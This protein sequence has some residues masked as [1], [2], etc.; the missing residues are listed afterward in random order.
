MRSIRAAFVLS[1]LPVAAVGQE[2][3]KRA[4]V[5]RASGEATVTAKPDRAQLS[6]GVVTQA[7]TAQ[8]ASK[9]N[10]AK[11]T[12]V[13]DAI[14]RAL[15]SGG[16]VNTSGY[17]ISPDYSYPK[18]EAPKIAAYHA[19]N[20]VMV[21]INDLASVGKM[22]DIATGSGA[23]AI[24][25][26]SFTLQNDE[27]VRTQALA[28]AAVKARANA[29][30]IARALNLQIVGVLEAQSTEATAIRPLFVPVAEKAMARAETPVE[31]GSLDIHA[32]VTVTLEVR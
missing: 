32:S 23:N 15:S 2:P 10:A 26:I 1:L 21:T 11:T 29:E 30:A 13:L 19:S 25:G 5:V 20:T 17:S 6:I 27:P 12:Q 22:V 18:N 28:E 9:Q 4:H 3:M 8:E 24:T 16:E 14:K 31:P 7:P